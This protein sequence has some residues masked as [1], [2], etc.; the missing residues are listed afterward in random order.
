MKITPEDWRKRGKTIDLRDGGIFAVDLEG[1]GVPIL[2]LHGF[3]T[4]SWD[5]AAAATH[6]QDKG[7][8]VVL[9]DFL[10]FGFS[11]K[12]HDAAY[13]LLEQAEIAIGVAR[14]LRL[15]RVHVWAHDMGTSVA[16]E[17][18]AL[19][20]RGLLPFGVT[21]VT[22]M[23]GSVHIEMANPTLGQRLLRSPLGNAFARLS[24]K[25]VFEQQMRGIFA[26]K[27]PP[28]QH[29]LDAMWSLLT[30]ADGQLRLPA[31][32]GYM[33][34]RTRFRR[35]WIGALERLDI[36]MFVAWGE[37]DPVA[38]LA[39]AE[40][41]ARETPGADLT[42]WDDLGHYPQVEAPDRVAQA[43]ANFIARVE[44]GRASMVD[45]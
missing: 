1:S 44:D 25:R 32:I 30:R 26:P 45:G 34:E 41:L 13:S 20:E 33:A 35:R 5:F 9:F 24:S 40:R 6:L 14:E 17:L 10:G 12:P 7:R 23:N 42:T 11:D 37:L 27:H 38:K 21:S 18:L 19:R 43:V 39:I 22:L 2:V 31:I 28:A 16:T 8:R 15:K 3:P 4:S 29:E 36:P